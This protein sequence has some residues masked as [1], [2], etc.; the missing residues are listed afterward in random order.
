MISMDLLRAQLD[1]GCPLPPHAT[2]MHIQRAG[3][4][5]P[6]LCAS[7][8]CHLGPALHFIWLLAQR[9]CFVSLCLHLPFLP[10]GDVTSVFHFIPAP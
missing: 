1:I 7:P 2:Q 6:R 3:I 8:R 5:F 9:C 4:I 10:L